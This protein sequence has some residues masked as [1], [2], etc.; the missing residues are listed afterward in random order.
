MPITKIT[1][2]NEKHAKD[3]ANEILAR[4]D[5]ILLETVDRINGIWWESMSEDMRNAW[6]EYRQAL[7]DITK[8]S[9]YPFM[10]EWPTEPKT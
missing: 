3:K 9:G 7:L 8:Q 2:D 1:V 4:R 6:R 5:K 10:V